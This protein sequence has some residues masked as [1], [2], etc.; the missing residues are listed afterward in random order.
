MTGLD[1]WL[2][3]ATRRLA[4]DSAAQVRIEIRE[5]Y[6]SARE[7]AMSDGANT[8]EADRRHWPR[9]GMRRPRTANIAKSC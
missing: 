4:K 7:V 5:H 2:Q 9:W 1:I 3:Q 6:E 8:L